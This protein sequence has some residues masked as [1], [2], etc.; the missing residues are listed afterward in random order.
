M[1]PSQLGVVRTFDIPSLQ[2]DHLKG[3]WAEGDEDTYELTRIPRLSGLGAVAVCPTCAYFAEGRC[4]WCPEG[5]SGP[6][7]PECHQCNG[8]MLQKEPWYQ[9]SEITVPL[10]TTVAVT[11]IATVASSLILRR[12]GVGR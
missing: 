10:V 2:F 3:A 12:V 11:V 7:F 4:N 5:D 8:R 1:Y 6:D 9:R